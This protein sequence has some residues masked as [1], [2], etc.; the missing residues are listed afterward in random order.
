MK[1]NGNITLNALGQSEVQ[2]LV[3]ERLAATPTFHAAE[4]GRLIYNTVDKLFYMNTGLAWVALATG[5]DAASLQ[6]EVDNLEA[7]L[8]GAIT[9]TGGFNAGAITAV[10]ASSITDAINKL[11]DS[12][13]GKDSL[14]KLLDVALNA[15]GTGQFLRF[16]AV[17]GKWINHTPVLADISDV[18]AT[19]A[20]V[21][22]LVGVT[23]PVQG[24]IDAVKA[25]ADKAATDL[26]AEVT[27]ATGEE[28]R[29]EGLVTAEKDRA[30]AAEQA[31][32]DDLAEEILARLAAEGEASADLEAAKTALQLAIDLKVSKAGDSMTGQLAMG[33][34]K[35][36]GLAA[37]TQADDAASKNYVDNLLAGLSWLKAVDFSPETLE[38]ANGGLAESYIDGTRIAVLETNKIYVFDNAKFYGEPGGIAALDTV[39]LKEGDAFFAKDTETGYVVNMVYSA[40]AGGVVPQFVQFTGGGQLAAGVGLSKNGNQ[41]DVNLGAGIAQLPSDE[42]GVDVL[43]TGGLFLTEDGSTDSTG[44]AAQLAVKL[45]GNTITRGT[46]GIKVSDAVVASIAANATAVADEKVRAEAA[47][48]ANADAIAAEKVRAEAAELANADAIAAEALRADTAEKAIAADL[49]TEVTRATEAEAALAAKLAKGYFLYDGVEATSHAVVHNIGSRFCNVTVIDSETNEQIIPQAVIFDSATQ[50]TVTF[51]VALACKV[52]VMGLGVDLV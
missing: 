16:D 38:L 22:H 5:G 9:A 43:G 15:P 20:E 48:K 4:A 39:E 45:D 1:F 13:A 23:A 30:E 12:V 41:I 7:S 42:V 10:A 51:N 18:T 11:G 31:I 28:A 36:I 19:A 8:G 24:Q 2:N 40:D 46:G 35:I 25:T 50:L 52:V 29:I 49:A 44:T 47:E 34:N 37:P 32:A 3:V 21:N 27:R 17:S 26:A 6:T 14:S 33:G